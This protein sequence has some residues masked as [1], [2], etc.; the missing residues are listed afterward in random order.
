M[1]SLLSFSLACF[2]LTSSYSLSLFETPTTDDPI[3]KQLVIDTDGK[4]IYLILVNTSDQKQSFS[5]VVS[6]NEID[7]FPFLSLTPKDTS[8][9][10]NKTSKTISFTEKLKILSFHVLR[11]SKITN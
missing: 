5:L 3:T 10:T 8:N 6:N 9:K 11:I 7:I 4:N 2:F 1:K